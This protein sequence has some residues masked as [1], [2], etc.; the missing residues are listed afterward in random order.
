MKDTTSRT[1]EGAMPTPADLRADMA[2]HKVLRYELAAEV[3]INPG[4]LGEMLNEKVLMPDNIVQ[5]VS[6][7][8]VRRQDGR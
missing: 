7:A 4:R 6:E 2:R 3:G 8:L 1:Q 5:R